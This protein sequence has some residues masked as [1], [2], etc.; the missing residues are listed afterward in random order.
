MYT[1]K[2]LSELAGVSVRTLH[3]YDEIG[4]LKPSSV[5][6]NGYRY[7][8][9]AD[10][11]R[12]QQILFYR[13]MD[14]GLLQ[15]KAILD[16]P[17][18]DLVSALQAHRRALQAKID[19][20][21]QLIHTVDRTLIHVVGDVEMSKKK[22]MF[23]GFSDEKQKEYEQ[24][25]MRRYGE[26]TIKQSLQ[27]WNGYT[28]EQKNRIKEEGRDIYL[29][30]AKAMPTGHASDQTQAILARWHQH[31][32]Y[33]YEPSIEVLG[34]LGKV[35]SE[36]PDFNAFFAAIHPDLPEFISRAIAVYVDRLET[37]W[38]ERELGI[39]EE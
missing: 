34:G 1:V 25:A 9:D 12:L 37:E 38:L 26:D 11:F 20:M 22:K 14:L 7:Y 19:R 16:Q 29:D 28:D 13:E 8:D 31:L 39:L 32:R 17:D 24:E 15:I 35:Y 27:L 10:L 36:D 33:F 21:Q 5:G 18:F 23:A 2:Q 4:L 30:L 3:Y 6:K